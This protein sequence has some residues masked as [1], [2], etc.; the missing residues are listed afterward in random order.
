MD[1]EAANAAVGDHDVAPPAEQEVGHVAA[2]G[3]PDESPELE[4]VVDRRD[5]VRRAAD[6]HRRQ[7][8]EGR[9]AICTY[10]DP[11]GDVRL[12]RRRVEGGPVERRR[13]L[14]RGAHPGRLG[15]ALPP[16]TGALPP[17]TPGLRP[18]P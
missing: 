3:E 17:L 18:G 16:L 14:C 9:L 7:L 12:E 5:Q 10:P 6:A 2:P 8:A 4:A 1:D 13:A 15:T 11:A